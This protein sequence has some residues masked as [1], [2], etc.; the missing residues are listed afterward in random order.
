MSDAKALIQ[1][2]KGEEVKLVVNVTPVLIS[3]KGPTMSCIMML[4]AAQN[5]KAKPPHE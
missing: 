1:I 3:C 2:N 4:N 5:V